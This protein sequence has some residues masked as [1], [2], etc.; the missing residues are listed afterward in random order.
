MAYDGVEFGENAD[1]YIAAAAETVDYHNQDWNSAGYYIIA[2][3]TAPF[4]GREAGSILP[5]NM[6][7]AM[8]IPLLL[9]HELTG[10]SRYLEQASTLA[11]RFYD[12]LVL[13]RFWQATHGP[14]T[15]T[16]YWMAGK[17]SA[18]PLLVCDS[19]SPAGEQGVIFTDTDMTRFAAIVDRV[20]ID[21][22]TFWHGL[23]SR[24][25]TN[26]LDYQASLHE[27]LPLT[28][29]DASI[30][31]TVLNLYE[32]F[33]PVGELVS[34]NRLNGWAQLIEAQLP[35]CRAS[36]VQGDWLENA[37]GWHQSISNQPQIHVETLVD[38]IVPLTIKADSD[39]HIS[40]DGESTA[41]WQRTDVSLLRYLP[42]T[43]DGGTH[44]FTLD[45]EPVGSL[46]LWGL[47]VL[48][49]EDHPTDT[50]TWTDTAS[51][52]DT[53][54]PRN[55]TGDASNIASN[56]SDIGPSTDNRRA[57]GGCNSSSKTSISWVLVLLA[58]GWRRRRAVMLGGFGLSIGCG[59]VD[60]PSDWQSIPIDTASANTHP[61]TPIPAV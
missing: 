47:E 14:I 29:F 21:D 1:A 8:G 45:H 11:A 44:R 20:T 16:M 32:L 6:S 17:T 52:E 59:S 26:Y 56:E 40:Q 50:G 5:M 24:T 48:Q 61:W 25:K 39:I 2:E 37:E 43:A 55:D 38:C 18:M 15:W 57:C 27:W 53:A 9:L 31:A 51:P 30:Y 36:L 3:D 42:V 23:N 41:V 13:T 54:N 46:Q 22:R 58:L 28:P 35:E 60:E 33:Y 10:E 49:N 34:G 12:G 4:L 7:N 19:P